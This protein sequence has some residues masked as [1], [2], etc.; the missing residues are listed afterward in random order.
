MG[1]IEVLKLS[2]LKH[3]K[4]TNSQIRNNTKISINAFRFSILFYQQGIYQLICRKLIQGK[5]LA[6]AVYY[7]APT[8]NGG[9]FKN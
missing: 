3:T 8:R 6:N 1:S 4:S 9:G 5:L 2:W 7:G